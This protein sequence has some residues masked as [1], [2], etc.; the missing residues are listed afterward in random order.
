MDI[1]KKID[2]I[3]NNDL[4]KKSEL[5]DEIDK[6]IA[7]LSNLK[8]KHN[9]IL[10]QVNENR[11]QIQN[12]LNNLQ[13][14][15]NN[16]NL[17]SN[18]ASITFPAHKTTSQ[19]LNNEDLQKLQEDLEELRHYIETKVMEIEIK[20]DLLFNTSSNIDNNKDDNKDTSKDFNNINNNKKAD[21][22]NIN[23]DNNINNDRTNINNNFGEIKKS[24]N[25]IIQP[26]KLDIGGFAKIMKKVEEI[27][28]NHWEL[29][30]SFKRL[31][32]T[33]NL[34]DILED[35][36][37]LKDV[38]AD[39]CDIP[40]ID[41]FSHIFD[42]L[43]NNN[44]KL[45]SE[46]EEINKRLDNIYSS[47]LNKENKEDLDDHI[48]K[49]I[50]QAYVT[51]DDFDTHIKENED[52]FY[53]IKKEI[54]KIKDN[55][56]QVMNA[57][58][59]KAEQSELNMLRNNLIEK[60]EELVKACNLKFAD[61]NECLKNFK[62]IEEQLK[63]ILFLLKKRNE[64]NG[65]GDANNWLLAK[66]PINGYS[67]AS[68]ESYIGD[69]SNDIKKYIPWNRLPLRD[70]NENLYRMGS[71]YSKM[72]QMINFDNNGNV[73]IN[74][75]M[76]NEE[77]NTLMSSDS[78]IMNMNNMNMMGRT[79][80]AKQKHIQ[81]KTPIKIRIQSAS[82]DLVNE[83]MGNNNIISNDNNINYEENKNYW[84][85]NIN[86]VNNMN[87]RNKKTSGLPKIKSDNLPLGGFEKDEGNK[88]D[89]KIT[90][91]IRKSQSKGNIKQNRTK[92]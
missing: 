39:K 88:N 81:S 21:N 23:D 59:K 77:I 84:N 68:C 40:E 85:N 47:M 41:S 91:I 67:C 92:L 11:I 28:R 13:E 66:K 43:N 65:E 62:H 27:D 56:S 53:L 82:N 69:L 22:N 3:A 25:T 7:E 52:E 60:M 83:N 9:D 75:D 46:I 87:T 73:N 20:L 78:N 76:T 90:K 29:D 24:F 31:L 74:P 89:P 61:K 55:L 4:T 15:K 14:K 45:E 32:S 50:L 33:F 86:N 6:L 18:I 1:V 5:K 71:G 12:I 44:K 8:N 38:K 57:I 54:N 42:D 51:K 48:N 72:L 37:K 70:S 2:E 17:A 34:N 63:K 26:N 80:Y 64:Q 19:K 16:F 49:E 58:K 35:I 30:R 36:A 79:F 10:S